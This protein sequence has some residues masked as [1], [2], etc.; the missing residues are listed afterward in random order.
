MTRLLVSVRNAAEAEA[1]LAGGAALID[2]KEPARG[3]LGRCDDANLAA[4]LATVAG[5]VPVS[6]ALGE[7]GNDV[8]PPPEG[9]IFAKVGLAGWRHRHDWG[10]RWNKVRHRW[11]DS[12]LA[13]AV[14]YA[15]SEHADA[16]TLDA[17]FAAACAAKA[18]AILI[19]TFQKNGTTLFDYLPMRILSE[20][21]GHCRA[22]GIPIALAGSLGFSQIEQLLPCKPDWIAVRGAACTGGR[23]GCIQEK[24]VRELALFIH[25]GA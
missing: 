1:A 5:Q 10:S 22:K 19:D 8:R 17:V 14:A 12:C 15:D 7:L 6:A 23:K 16:P 4:I 11:P 2:A 9:V 25:G 13:V 18:G 21:I 3:P 20:F 24:L